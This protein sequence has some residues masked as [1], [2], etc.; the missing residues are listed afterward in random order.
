MNYIGQLPTDACIVRLYKIIKEELIA[1]NAAEFYDK[2]KAIDIV[3][4]RAALAGRVEIE[5][6]IKD[7]FADVY[8]TNGDMVAT[9]ALDASSYRSLKNKWMKCKIER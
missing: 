3:L 4:R 2:R 7:H 1:C 6:D 5:G 9:V 8:N